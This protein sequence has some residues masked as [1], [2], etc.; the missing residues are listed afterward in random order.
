MPAT[1]GVT[2]S[3]FR[4]LGFHVAT[5]AIACKLATLFAVFGSLLFHVVGCLFGGS[6]QFARKLTWIL[7]RTE[8]AIDAI[9]ADEDK[10]GSVLKGRGSSSRGQRAMDDADS[11]SQRQQ[12][13]IVGR[14]QCP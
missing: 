10:L 8:M 2:A 3:V 14:S 9:V 13:H 7:W 4:K 1:S 6:S 5:L 12:R 11:L